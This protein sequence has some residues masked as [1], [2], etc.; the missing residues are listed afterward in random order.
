VLLGRW[1][2]GRWKKDRA[3]DH[4]NQHRSSCVTGTRPGDFEPAVSD[5]GLAAPSAEKP[6]GSAS[7][8]RKTGRYG[9]PEAG[10]DARGSCRRRVARAV[11]VPAG[12]RI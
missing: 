3:I 6:G 11:R 12:G 10:V 5:E 4:H 2:L 9:I 8:R 7:Q 1:G